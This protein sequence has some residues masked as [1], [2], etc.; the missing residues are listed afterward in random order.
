MQSMAGGS[1]PVVQ[2]EPRAQALAWLRTFVASGASGGA[3][4]LTRAATR[5]AAWSA[6]RQVH[7][8]TQV[9]GSIDGFEIALGRAG[10]LT[11]PDAGRVLGVLEGA[12]PTSALAARL[13]TLFQASVEPVI[14]LAIAA[15]LPE[16]RLR[17]ALESQPGAGAAVAAVLRRNPPGTPPAHLAA[18]RARLVQVQAALAAP[19]TAGVT[20]STP[21]REARVVTILT[22]PAVAHA[23][24]AAA[25]AGLPPPAFIPAGYYRDVVRALHA[26][27]LQDWAWAQPMDRRR[28]LDT[29]A[30]GHIERI[31]REAKD[32]VDALFGAYGSRPAPALTFSAGTLEDR[33]TITGDPYDLARWYVNEGSD[34]PAMIAA[35]EAHHA[36]E[37]AAAAQAIENQVIS[38]Y[39]GRTA[40]TVAGEVAALASVGMA[41]SE[42]ARRLTI[43]DRM[44][45][46]AAGRGRV[47]V[48]AREGASSAETRGIYW[49]LFKTMLHEYLH[50]TEN[51]A[52]SAW[53]RGLRESHHRTTYQEGVTDLFTLRTWRSV[54]PVE[55]AANR[56]FR[57]RIQGHADPDLDMRAVGGE[58]SHYAE[59]AEARQIEALIGEANLKAAYFRGNVAVLG[60]RGLPR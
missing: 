19:T 59:L 8:V 22:P 57:Q 31:A 53:Y 56:A 39:S 20:A 7:L 23:R 40:P 41:A 10:L 27:M 48:A 11:E 2:R 51:T 21:T 46:G 47:S 54:C 30:G 4:A 45:P 24:A 14:G 25:A 36:F 58:P 13:V 18:I 49:G 44:W 33:G 15:N 52:Y 42:R 6:D 16:D 12:Q 1:R 60:G 29:T 50:T 55:V 34:R 43:I 32:R 5:L 17:A 9:R 38:H 3:V 37:N 26:S 28:T 35:K